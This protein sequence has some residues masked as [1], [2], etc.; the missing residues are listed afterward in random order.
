M[1]RSFKD[2]KEKALKRE[3]VADAFEQLKPEYEV[4]KA[5]IKAR[6]AAHMTQSEVAEKMHT[7]QAAIARYES[8]NHLPSLKTI[9]KYAKAV[10]R[11]ISLKIT[12][13]Q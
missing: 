5:L 7:S 13:P 2:F 1:K 11:I 8:G 10:G 9:V 12:P 6:G 4:A 3:S